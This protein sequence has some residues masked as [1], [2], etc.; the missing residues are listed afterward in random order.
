MQIHRKI[1]SPVPAIL[2]GLTVGVTIGAVIGTTLGLTLAKLYGANASVGPEGLTTV[3]I[4][5]GV[6]AGSYYGSMVAY[7]GFRKR[8]HLG[9]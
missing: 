5:V 2:K 7:S 3:F 6:I 9:I 4:L 8:N 1:P